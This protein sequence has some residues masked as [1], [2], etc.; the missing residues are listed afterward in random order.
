MA[1]TESLRL[2]ELI[3]AR[4]CHDMSGIFG[5]LNAG[6]EMVE[7][8]PDDAEA[9]SIVRDASAELILRLRLLRLAWGPNPEPLTLKAWRALALGS[10]AARRVRLDLSGLPP[11][12]VLPP[13]VARL[14]LNLFLLASESLPAGGEVLFTGRDDDL[15]VHILGPGARWP[16]G[17][18]ACLANEATAASA[19]SGARELQMPLTALMAHG[20]GLHL[21]MLM[22]IL[23]GAGAP[24]LRL[25]TTTELR[26]A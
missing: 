20:A 3:C 11:E 12:T 17:T 26:S 4:L 18:A 5:T 23:P 14:A 9:L 24:P 16:V 8:H 13:M 7:E 1:A 19:L 10:P 15:F 22:P 2:A 25:Q 6:L 21:S